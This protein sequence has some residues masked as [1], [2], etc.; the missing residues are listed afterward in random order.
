[1]AEFTDVIVLVAEPYR[2]FLSVLLLGLDDEHIIEG[3]RVVYQ[4]AEDVLWPQV[5][6]GFANLELL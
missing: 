4:R 1:L 6:F 2:A 5:L 3:H